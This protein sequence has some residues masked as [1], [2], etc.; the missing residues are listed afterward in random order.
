MFNL[1]HPDTASMLAIFGS[2]IIPAL[3]ALIVKAKLSMF[4]VGLTTLVISAANGFITTW[5]DAPDPGHY[6][7]YNALGIS[8]G[9]LVVAFLTHYVVTAGTTEYNNL[10]ARGIK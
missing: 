5:A 4:W 6:P 7:V 1:F 3:S 2:I 10:H 9:S 8:L